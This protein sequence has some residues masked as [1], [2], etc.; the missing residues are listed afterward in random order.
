MQSK[1]CV[2]WQEEMNQ[3]TQDRQVLSNSTVLVDTFS[4]APLAPKAHGASVLQ[5]C[6][7]AQNL[8]L[9]LHLPDDRTF[10]RL[11]SELKEAPIGLGGL[12][13]EV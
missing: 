7:A 5:I 9:L 11:F 10:L 12:P 3:E 2:A 8:R 13:D 6:Q 4:W 1:F